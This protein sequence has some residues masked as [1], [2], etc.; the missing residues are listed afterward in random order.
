MKKSN[1][2]RSN[3]KSTKDEITT[4][5]IHKISSS[6]SSNSSLPVNTISPNQNNKSTTRKNDTK[7]KEIADE[8]VSFNNNESKSVKKVF[9]LGDRIIKYAKS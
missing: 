5:L 6:S 8:T 9:I 7:D 2:Q 3:Q 4:N 1:T